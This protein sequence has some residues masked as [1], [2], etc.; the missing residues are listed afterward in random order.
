MNYA[1][2][3]R[4]SRWSAIVWIVVFWRLGYAS[5]LDPDEAHYAELT[6]EMLHAHSWLV[7]LLDGRAYIDKP[8]LFHWLQG[9]AVALTG[10]SEFAVRL[11]SAVAALGLFAFVRWVGTRLFNVETGEAGALMLATIPATFALSSVGLVDMVYTLFLFGGVGCLLVAAFAAAPYAQWCGFG[12]LALAV[13]T[14]G[15]IA[16]VLVALFFGLSAAISRES[17]TALVSLDWSR[18]C[19]LM[20]AV[21]LPWFGW[22]WR[23]FGDQFVSKYLLAGNVWYFT[24]PAWF[25]VKAANHMFY[26]R[27]FTAAFFPWS[28]LVLGSV[29][30]AWA[31]TRVRA[32]ISVAAMQ[33]WIW[34]FVVVGFFSVACFKLD[35]YIF[36]AA[37]ACC[38]I[39]ARAWI[40]A[41]ID[42]SWHWTRRAVIAIAGS[43]VVLGVAGAIALTRIDLGLTSAAFALPFVLV[44]GGTVMRWQLRGRRWVPRRLMS[45][46]LATLLLTYTGLVALGLPVL[47]RSRPGSSVGRWIAK[48]VQPGEPVALYRLERFRASTRYYAGRPIGALDDLSSL[49]EF[50]EVGGQKYVVMLRSDFDEARSAG[51]PIIDVF[52]RSIVVR[53]SGKGFRRQHWGH[54]VIATRAEG[55]IGPDSIHVKG[56]G[57]DA[58]KRRELTPPG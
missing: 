5:L 2:L 31:N 18:G 26:V 16:L 12:L 56:A 52:A 19:A 35:H 25:P 17:R 39:A 53:T 1:A 48:H 34:L 36:P 42:E 44:S 4:F 33:L 6:R 38:L 43:F 54:I 47:E 28:F 24:G 13:M 32:Q 51:V 30:D 37:P 20:A 21:A 41:G 49:R 23:Q 58:E 22:M 46:P 55:D 29:A 14:K 57:S 7:P 9:L 45:V 10:E 8:V 40:R 15:P 3:A 27:V 50:L 11:P